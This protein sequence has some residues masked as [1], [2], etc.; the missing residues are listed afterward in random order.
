MKEERTD[1]MVFIDLG[2]VL[3]V[4]FLILTETAPRSNV[5]LPGD[6][7]EPSESMSE[8]AVFNV[9]FNE[10][11]HFRVENGIQSFCELDEPGLL[12]LCLHEIV[13]TSVGAVFVL[14]PAGRATVQQLVTMLDLCE[15]NGWT[16]TVSN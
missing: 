10:G 13:Q 8:L 9:H 1:L 14:V 12:Q 7:E 6:V 5:A 16:C 15:L 3:L 2:F 4:G 11:G